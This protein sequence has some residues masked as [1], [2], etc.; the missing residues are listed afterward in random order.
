MKRLLKGHLE[1][2]RFYK[3]NFKEAIKVVSKYLKSP[4]IKKSRPFNIPYDAKIDLASVQTDIG[5]MVHFGYIKHP[6]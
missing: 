3:D 6:Y 1:A 2:V 5:L 4:A